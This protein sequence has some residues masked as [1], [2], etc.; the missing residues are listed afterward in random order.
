MLPTEDQLNL[1]ITPFDQ[2]MEIPFKK[3]V[4]EY[5]IFNDL[6][7]NINNIKTKDKFDSQLSSYKS[8]QSDETEKKEINIEKHDVNFSDDGRSNELE[9]IDHLINKMKR[10][11][12]KSFK[13]LNDIS[14]DTI[15]V[16]QNLDKIDIHKN[17]FMKQN[18]SESDNSF[19]NFV[20]L[21]KSKTI[22]DSDIKNYHDEGND[23]NNNEI[24][25][26]AS[27]IRNFLHI[28]TFKEESNFQN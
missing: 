11:H 3:D 17:I 20:N 4:S 5:N 25:K 27:Q 22:V 14:D 12:K 7:N 2:E 24:N 21:K 8:N 18:D 19:I 23:S 16:K 15:E 9:D 13:K 1:I 28:K 10:N 26:N 6:I